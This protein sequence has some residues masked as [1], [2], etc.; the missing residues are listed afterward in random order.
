MNALADTSEFHSPTPV[1]SADAQA[2]IREY[3]HV[4]RVRWW[5]L[6]GTFL[7]SITIVGLVT[8]S[9]TPVFRSTALLL[10]EARKP[11]VANV[12]VQEVYDMT[13]GLNNAE[14]YQTQFGILK[15]R[16]I[17]EPVADGLRASF[18]EQQLTGSMITI[19]PVG[20]SRLVRVSVDSSDKAFATAAVNALLDHYIDDT[21]QRSS[22][23]SDRGLQKLQEMEKQLRP[24]YEESARREQEFREQNKLSAVDE[25]QSATG[26]QLKVLSEELSRVRVLRTK[27]TA[28]LQ[29]A[30]AAI[31]SGTPAGFSSETASTSVA[32]NVKTEMIKLEI[33]RAEL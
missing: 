24:Q 15:S 7:I 22:G 16:R 19:E 1:A 32:G 17:V 5:A 4:V 10:I 21:A 28:D 20:E 6:L 29:A 26:Q 3:L 18:P 31:Q 25:S 30:E 11:N 8:L 14:Y 12:N 27:A 13:M 9:Q 33:A 2:L 23:V